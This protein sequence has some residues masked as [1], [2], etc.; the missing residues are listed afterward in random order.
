MVNFDWKSYLT[1]STEGSAN[2]TDSEKEFKQLIQLLDVDSLAEQS[3]KVYPQ[4][5]WISF[6]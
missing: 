6:D 3:T 1:A 2:D 4:K 5:L